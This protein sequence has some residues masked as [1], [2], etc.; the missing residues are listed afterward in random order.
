[1]QL[2]QESQNLFRWNLPNHVAAAT[3]DHL[4][5]LGIGVGIVLSIARTLY[6]DRKRRRR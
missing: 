3:I 5:Y 2:T 6:V 4:D 1:L